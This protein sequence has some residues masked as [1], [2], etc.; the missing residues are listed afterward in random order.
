[1][2][3]KFSSS[4]AQYCTQYCVFRCSTV[5]YCAQYVLYCNV[6]FEYVYIVFQCAALKVQ[7]YSSGTVEVLL[8]VC[9]CV[10]VL[11][12][13]GSKQLRCGGEQVIRSSCAVHSE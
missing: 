8:C 4:G 9:V 1:M 7:K 13:S 12:P 10:C 5:Q 2:Y 6:L 11:N 3:I